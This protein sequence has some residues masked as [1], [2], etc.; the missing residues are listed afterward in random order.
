MIYGDSHNTHQIS[1]GN[2]N[3]KYL[4]YL[5]F[6]GGGPVRGDGPVGQHPDGARGGR[7]PDELPLG[8]RQCW[9]ESSSWILSGLLYS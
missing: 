7:R 6:T 2:H 4:L 1:S 5:Q 8:E 3:I 9:Q